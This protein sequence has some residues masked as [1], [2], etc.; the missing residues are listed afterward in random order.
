M[1]FADLDHIRLHYRI[2]GDPDGAPIVFAN[3]LGTD[4]RLWDPIISLLPKGL[5]IIRYD[6]RGHGKSDCP[7]GPYSMGALVRDAEG[8]DL[9]SVALLEV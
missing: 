9:I 4:M 1:P 7:E 2:D 6:M 8:L 5:R 3:S